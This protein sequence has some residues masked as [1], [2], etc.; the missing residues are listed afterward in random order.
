MREAGREG[1]RREGGRKG[2]RGQGPGARGQGQ[3]PGLKACP[4][5]LSNLR[6]P[7]KGA[8]KLLFRSKRSSVSE[9]V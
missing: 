1:Q 7:G 4:W 6:G 3:G 8:D 2:G 5:V 9:T